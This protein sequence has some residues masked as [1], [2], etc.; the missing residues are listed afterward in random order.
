[1]A[2]SADALLVVDNCF[3]T[4]VLQKPLQWGADI[5]VHSATKYIDGQGR[6]LGG[7]VVGSAALMEQVEGFLRAAGPTMS[8]FNA[9]VFLKGLETLRIRMQAHSTNAAALANWLQE[10]PAVAKVYYSGLANH[11]GHTL[12][13]K[14]QSDF[15]GVVAFEVAGGQAAAWRVIDSTQMLSLTA[16]LGDAKT[17]IVHPATTTHGR[18]S[19]EERTQAGIG[20]G[21]IR[22][23]VGLE[24]I[25]DIKADLERGLAAL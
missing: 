4:P 1:V 11:P 7:A 3:C 25:I 24:D 12:A 13:K 21:L 10:H 20:D 6:C 19:D 18:L 22:V 17:T 15:G 16:N 9:W 2:K 14:Q 5:V 23:A 8:P